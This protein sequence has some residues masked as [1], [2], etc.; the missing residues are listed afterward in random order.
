MT[1]SMRG[2]DRGRRPGGAHKKN[3]NRKTREERVTKKIK[4]ARWHQKFLEKL[5]TSKPPLITGPVVE[6]WS[7]RNWGSVCTQL[8]STGGTGRKNRTENWK[9]MT[10]LLG[11]MGLGLRVGDPRTRNTGSVSLAWKQW[12]KPQKAMRGVRGSRREKR[13]ETWT[14]FKWKAWSVSFQWKER[15]TSKT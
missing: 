3:G 7:H 12:S 6:R 2:G 13:R 1:Y 4:R 11:Y 8:P 5:R 15:I 9:G 10:L 14:A